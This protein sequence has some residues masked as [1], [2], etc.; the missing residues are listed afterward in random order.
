[1]LERKYRNWEGSYKN[2]EEISKF[3][4]EHWNIAKVINKSTE[5]IDLVMVDS[6]ELINLKVFDN[7]YAPKNLSFHYLNLN[8]FI[9]VTNFEGSLKQYNCMK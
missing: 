4:N 6:N 1:M 9:F 7:M 5:H 2:I 3:K 8:D